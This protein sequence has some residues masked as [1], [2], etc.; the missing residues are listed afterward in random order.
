MY[1]YLLWYYNKKLKS[2]TITIKHIKLN[3]DTGNIETITDHNS[4]YLIE[5]VK[6]RDERTY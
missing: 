3:E 5:E 1:M 4:P 6:K 2:G